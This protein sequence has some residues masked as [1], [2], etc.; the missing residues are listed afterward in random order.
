MLMQEVEGVLIDPSK[1]WAI[2]PIKEY[3][4]DSGSAKYEFSIMVSSGTISVIRDSF[5]EA[6]VV[7]HDVANM[8]NGNQDM[9]LG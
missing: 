6:S 2:S 3:L 4:D 8:K 9:L 1:I 5:D 7:R